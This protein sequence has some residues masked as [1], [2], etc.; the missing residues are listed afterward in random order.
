MQIEEKY[1][2]DYAQSLDRIRAERARF[3]AEL[4]RL[5]NLRVIPSQ[6]NYLMVELLGGLSSRAVTRELLIGS[7][8]LVKDLSAKLGGRQYLRL[9]VR[10]TEDNDKLLAALRPLCGQ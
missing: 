2:K 4:E 7:R 8:I 6:A 10:N 9:A 1:K 3:R 5:S